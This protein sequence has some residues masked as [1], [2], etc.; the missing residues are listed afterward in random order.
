MR[1]DGWFVYRLLVTIRFGCAFYATFIF[2]KY[3]G[4]KFTKQVLPSVEIKSFKSSLIIT[5]FSLSNGPN[6]L[7][8][9]YYLVDERGLSCIDIKILLTQFYSQ[10][11][12]HSSL[13]AFKHRI[14]LVTDYIFF[15]IFYARLTIEAGETGIEWG[16][17]KE[18]LQ[19]WKIKLFIMI[20][21]T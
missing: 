9:E 14:S 7:L 17:L 10:K 4:L 8:L 13:S 5:G 11:L 20:T 6:D 21:S 3:T 1:L 18:K 19:I 12:E 2:T 15:S 16:T